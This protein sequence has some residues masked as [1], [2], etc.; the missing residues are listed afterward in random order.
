MENALVMADNLM[1]SK[2]TENLHGK[3]DYV[4]ND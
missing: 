4:L 3:L 1:L 2:L